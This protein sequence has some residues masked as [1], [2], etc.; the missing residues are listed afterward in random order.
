ML[1]F[2]RSSRRGPAPKA[3]LEEA[4]GSN[5]LGNRK[6]W[7]TWLAKAL[8]GAEPRLREVAQDGAG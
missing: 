1:G 5:K 2:R 4:L 7:A 3:S 6:L 8:G